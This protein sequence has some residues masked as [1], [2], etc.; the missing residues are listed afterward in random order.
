[1]MKTR[2][3]RGSAGPR[4]SAAWL[5]GADGD[6]KELQLSLAQMRSGGVKMLS[7][8]AKV[9][10]GVGEKQELDLCFWITIPGFNKK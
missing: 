2:P 9:R 8:L 6:R 10:E 4:E 7:A 1:M 3:W 5:G